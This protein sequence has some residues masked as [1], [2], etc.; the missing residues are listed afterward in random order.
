[1]SAIEKAMKVIQEL[2]VLE[3]KRNDPLK[4]DVSFQD[5]PIPVPINVGV[6]NGGKVCIACSILRLSVAL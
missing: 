1:V 6:I 2:Q 3:K 4:K 5:L